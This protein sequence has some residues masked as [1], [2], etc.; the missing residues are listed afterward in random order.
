MVRLGSANCSCGSRVRIYTSWTKENPGRRFARCQG[1]KISCNMPRTRRMIADAHKLNNG[2]WTFEQNSRFVT[3]LYNESKCSN[4]MNVHLLTGACQRIASEMSALCER[5]FSLCSIKNKMETE[6]FRN[7][8][9][10]GEPFHLK[11]EYIS[12][13]KG[14]ALFP[15]DLTGSPRI[16]HTRARLGR[17]L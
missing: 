7:F 4:L 2:G 9:M 5:R 12:D 17:R 6:W 16:A 14:V 3:L 13:T 11:L 8:R 15:K 10:N 1:L